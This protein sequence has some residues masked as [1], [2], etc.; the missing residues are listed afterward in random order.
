VA[1]PTAQLQSGISIVGHAIVSAD[2]MIAD[3]A[4]DMPAALRNDADWRTFQN[5]LV[6]AT[7]VVLG[8]LGHSRHPNPGRRRLVLTRSVATLRPDAD[9]PLALLWNPLG[10]P[11]ADVLDALEIAEGTIAVTGGTGVFDYFFEHYDRFDLS[12]VHDLV[13]PGGGP[14][15]SAGHPRTVLAAAGLVP[16]R[17]ELIDAAAG[18][19]TTAWQRPA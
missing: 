9:D 19:T 6:R 11:L 12:E 13:L 10:M 5:S 17:S 14:C 4:G 3:A 16:G 15:F 2:G 1:Q 8:R 18:V 7:L